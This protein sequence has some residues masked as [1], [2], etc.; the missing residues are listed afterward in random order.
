MCLLFNVRAFGGGF[1]KKIVPIISYRLTRSSEN[2][3][4]GSVHSLLHG[5]LHHGVLHL[6]SNPGAGEGSSF[7]TH[8]GLSWEGMNL[9]KNKRSPGL[10]PIDAMGVTVPKVIL[11]YPTMV[12]LV[13]I[14]HLNLNKF[15]FSDLGEKKPSDSLSSPLTTRRSHC[16]RG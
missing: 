6:F 11:H 10:D 1:C 5:V 3:K 8:R 15:L 9:S 16:G 14:P 12:L 7:V 4:N 13:H 2:I